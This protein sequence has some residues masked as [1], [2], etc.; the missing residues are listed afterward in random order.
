[1]IL[2][3][4]EQILKCIPHLDS[5]LIVTAQ[6]IVEYAG[7]FAREKNRFVMDD[8]IGKN[9]FHVFPGLTP[10]NSIACQVRKT[11]VPVL[12]LANTVCDYKNRVS[13]F[14][15]S[16]F[17][18]YYKNNIIGTVELS[19]Y[20]E[21]KYAN[22]S[23]NNE[24]PLYTLEHFITEDSAM[25]AQKENIRK[26]AATDSTVL[27][28]GET[29][30]GKEMIAQA[31]CS[32][33]PRANKPFLAVN[34]S[35][36]PPT[37]LDSTLFGTVKGSYTGAVERKGF[38]ENAKGGTLFF[39]ELNSMD[40]HLQA[41]LLRAIESKEIYRVGSNTPIP[42]DVRI[43]AAM[44]TTPEHAIAS[45]QL[46][47]DLYYRLGVAQ[48]N[49]PALRERKG[50]SPALCRH[51]LSQCEKKM[52]K[53]ISTMDLAVEE[54]FMDYDWP[55]NV[56]ELRNYIEYACLICDGHRVRLNDLPDIFVGRASNSK[57]AIRTTVGLGLKEKLELF[58]RNEI[59]TA[60]GLYRNL[61][62]VAEHLGIS[63][64]TLQYKMKKYDLK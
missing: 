59:E 14:I 8:Y 51:F 58:E 21:T 49:S 3:H 7:H 24:S 60:L 29:G 57:K 1:M 13:H 38:F 53:K 40:I 56:R 2:E 41:K 22:K 30:T 47:S 35:A 45:K 25:I 12:E 39:D 37:L 54:Q 43:I 28:C 6:N 10:E 55:G 42:T 34:C 32:H 4:M 11:G 17:P 15:S 62:D 20:D 33:S 18:L 16:T 5:V 9:I 64:Q 31:I 61:M 23:P 44:N 50:D 36:I 63:R 48:I 27:I 46:R 26:I 19:V 52:D